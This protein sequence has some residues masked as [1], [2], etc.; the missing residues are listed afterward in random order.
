MKKSKK[1]TKSSNL[2]TED[3]K[4]LADRSRDIIYHYTV[5]SGKFLFFNKKGLE[6]YGFGT[7]KSVLLLIDSDD[8][9]RVRRASKKSLKPGCTKGEVEYRI[10]L[11]DGSIRWMHDKWTVMRDESGNPLAIEGIIRDNT[12]KKLIEEELQKS[13]ERYRMLVDAM[14]DGLA[15]QDH[16]GLLTYVNDEFCR[17]LKYSIDDFLGKSI[18]EFIDEDQKYIIKEQL[19]KRKGN[20]K[21]FEIIF[22]RKDRKKIITIVSMQPIYDK[23]DN[24]YGSFVIITDISDIKKV[25]RELK[26]REKDLEMKSR[27]LDDLKS[28]LKVLLKRREE[29]QKEIEQNIL[30]NFKELIEPYLMQ[31]KECNL[32]KRQAGLVN[33]LEPNLKEIIS[34]FI[35]KISQIHLDF[36]PTEIKVANFVKQGRTSKEIAN[37]LGISTRTVDN[38]RNRIRKKLNINSKKSNLR[39]VLLSLQR[40]QSKS[41]IFPFL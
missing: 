5:P 7:K 39:T 4:S 26:D 16:T 23:N 10:C 32:N 19:E 18:T 20:L 33:I 15:V 41:E 2:L 17:M 40:D 6:V 25:V 28:A 3:Y 38:H 36:T 27:A 9:E 13:R 21:R 24:F 1:N 8:R 22:I 11:K 35:S 31:L 37:F 30:Y 14:N 34:P 29:D 12:E